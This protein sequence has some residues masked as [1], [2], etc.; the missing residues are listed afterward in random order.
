[1]EIDISNLIEIVLSVGST[2]NWNN[3][4]INLIAAEIRS[5]SR[6]CGSPDVMSII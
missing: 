1:M 3:I 4:N 2:D 5:S 6:S